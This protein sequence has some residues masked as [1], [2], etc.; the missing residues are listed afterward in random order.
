[1]RSGSIQ[2]FKST[3]SRDAV[4]HLSELSREFGTS[5]ATVFSKESAALFF[6]DPWLVDY[7]RLR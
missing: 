6:V 5:F 7:S 1:M 4:K 2:A 3:E